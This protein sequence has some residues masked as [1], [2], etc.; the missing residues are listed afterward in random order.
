MPFQ[1]IELMLSIVADYNSIKN[2]IL[3]HKYQ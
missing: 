2:K 3:Y 1:G